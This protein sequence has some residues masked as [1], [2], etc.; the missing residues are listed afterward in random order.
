[1]RKGR[2][3]ACRL[4]TA[5]RKPLVC[6]S[7]PHDSRN[8]DGARARPRRSLGSRCDCPAYQPSNRRTQRNLDRRI[9]QLYLFRAR[10]WKLSPGCFVGGFPARFSRAGA[11]D[12]GQN[13]KSQCGA[14]GRVAGRRRS[15]TGAGCGA[16]RG[17][18]CG[19]SRRWQSWRRLSKFRGCGRR[20]RRRRSV[21]PHRRGQ[22]R[23]GSSFR[24]GTT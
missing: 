13:T 9:G 22:W 20:P 24:G 16:T 11:R 5:Q 18:S 6:P 2:S 10:P 19:G 23:G 3:N 21:T 14:G 12:S 17:Q 1:M 8:R 7:R 4:G 15:A